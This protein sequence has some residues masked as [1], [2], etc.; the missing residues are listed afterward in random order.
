M[1]PSRPSLAY[2]E[3]RSML[4]P[5]FRDAGL[6]LVVLF[7][8]TARG[9][10]GRRSD[11]DLAFLFDRPCNT[12][13]LGLEVTRLLHTNA[14]D[15]VD[16]RTASPLLRFAALRDGKPLYERSPGTFLSSYSLAF[17]MYVDTKKLRDAQLSAIRNYLARMTHV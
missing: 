10:A 12:V 7:G 17:R 16:L 1:Q 3:L 14:V 6:Q 11:V 4:S 2:E 15:V 8:S 13:Q 5:L 9:R